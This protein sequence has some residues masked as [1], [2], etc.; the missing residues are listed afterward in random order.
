MNFDRRIFLAATA[1]A[2]ASAA[3]PAIAQ[4]PAG[5]PNKPVTLVVTYPPGGP[6]DTAGRVLSARLQEM[7]KQP[8]IVENRPGA[9]GAIGAAI[10]SRAAPDG[11]TLLVNS[12]HHAV[13]PSL[14]PNTGYDVIKDF[15]PVSFVAQY[16]VFLIAHP[17]APF[18]T[19]S[20]LIAYAKKNPGKV[21]YASAG[22]GGGTHMA[23]ELFRLQTGTQLLQIPYKGSAAAVTDV[24]GGQV[25]MM[26]ADGPSAVPHIKKGSVKVLAVGSPKRS[27]LLPEV[28]TFEEAGLKGYQAYAWA[29]VLAPT[30]TPKAIV[31]K[32][33][34]DIKVALNHPDSKKR[35]FGV[36]GTAAPSTPEQYGKFFNSEMT[37]WAKVVKDGNIK[38]D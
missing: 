7:W 22:S 33:S 10:A 11:Y 14:M 17:S 26:F 23:G 2:F 25:N 37:K 13:L 28:P 34:A 35:L 3:M 20:E 29:G 6:L 27:P 32:L 19:V 36:G 38:I 12:F 16:D 15:T 8:V 18:N 1:A 30:G 24:L 5:F 9:N 21:T 31:D 4:A